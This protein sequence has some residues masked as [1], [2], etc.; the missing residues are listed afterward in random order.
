MID[1]FVVHPNFKL[2]FED[3]RSIEIESSLESSGICS[4]LRII[5][6]A[7]FVRTVS[8]SKRRGHR[9][10][11]EN[12]KSNKK[13]DLRKKEKEMKEKTSGSDVGCA[14]QKRI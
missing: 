11:R 8:C 5:F 9:R 3:F 7:S 12:R 13:N 2:Q 10:R 14:R 4:I 1:K 6:V